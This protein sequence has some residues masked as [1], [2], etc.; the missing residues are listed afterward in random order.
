M[1][2]SVPQGSVLEPVMYLI[3]TSDL[4]ASDNTT[5]AAFADD[6][7]ILATRED[8]AI[9]SIE[10]QAT[11]NKIEDWAKKRR[12]KIDQSKSTRITFILRNKT[13]PTVEMD[14]VDLPQKNDVKYL[15]MHF[16]R[17]LTWAQP[18]IPPPPPNG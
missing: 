2:G 10:L 4:P 7:A 6:T 15:G 5:A 3:Y 18:T 9:A 13:C 14:N 1:E 16:E 17:K 8:P 11:L 12:I